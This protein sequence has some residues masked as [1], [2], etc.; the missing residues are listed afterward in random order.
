MYKKGVIL[1]TNLIKNRSKNR[2]NGQIGTKQ[3]KMPL[4]SYLADKF[5][6]F[7]GS[8]YIT[9]K[10]DY[11]VSSI[12]YLADKLDVRKASDLSVKCP[13]NQICPL[14]KLSKIRQIHSYLQIIKFVR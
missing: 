8:F 10:F 9:D 13:I 4:L 1:R 14:N 7:Y 11:F 5:D 6:Y 12:I 2:F 3:R